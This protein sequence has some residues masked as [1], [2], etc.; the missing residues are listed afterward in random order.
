MLAASMIEVC[1]F[2]SQWDQEPNSNSQLLGNLRFFF[3]LVCWLCS[4]WD[5]VVKGQM[6][7]ALYLFSKIYLN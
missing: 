7:T 6:S 5:L 3:C 2:S 1:V 4:R